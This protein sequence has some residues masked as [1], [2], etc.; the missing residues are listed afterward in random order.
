MGQKFLKLK[1]AKKSFGNISSRAGEQKD[2]NYKPEMTSL[3]ILNKNPA[4]KNKSEVGQSWK[5]VFEKKRNEKKMPKKNIFYEKL[6][7]VIKKIMRANSKN[8]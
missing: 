6:T 5:K 2:I 7:K 4:E 8:T 1:K 3:D